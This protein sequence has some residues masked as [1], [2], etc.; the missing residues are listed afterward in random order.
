MSRILLQIIGTHGMSHCLGLESMFREVSTRTAV[1]DDKRWLGLRS[2]M[3]KREKS[4]Q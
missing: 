2:G 3:D 4:E 1:G